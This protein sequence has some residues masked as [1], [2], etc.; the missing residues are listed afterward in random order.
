MRGGR[1]HLWVHG[2][3]QLTGAAALTA[4]FACGELKSEA[5][6][7][8]ALIRDGKARA[9]RT[10]KVTL[11][12]AAMVAHHALGKWEPGPRRRGQGRT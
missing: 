8:G 4:A 6:A 12:L 3:R 11:V 5:A 10:E 1:G 2:A 9:W 7:N